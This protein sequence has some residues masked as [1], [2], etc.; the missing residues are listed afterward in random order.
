MKRA[1]SGEASDVLAMSSALAHFPGRR[2]G[3]AVGQ[4]DLFH[5]LSTRRP[6]L[7]MKLLDTDHPF[8]RPLWVRILVFAVAAGWSGFEFWTGQP[9][10]GGI[11]LVFAAIS[12]YGFFINFDPDRR[13]RSG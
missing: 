2:A 12:F 1:P 6:A 4:R 10:W 8:F 5:V 3:K 9:I 11:F 13:N 7:K